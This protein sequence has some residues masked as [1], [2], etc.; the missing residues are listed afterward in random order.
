MFFIII[1]HFSIFSKSIKGTDRLCKVAKLSMQCCG[2]ILQDS[3]TRWSEPR[4]TVVCIYKVK[5]M[6][7]WLNTKCFRQVDNFFKSWFKMLRFLNS[8][9]SP[10]I[11]P[12]PP[13][14]PFPPPGPKSRETFQQLIIPWSFKLKA[15]VENFT[16]LSFYTLTTVILQ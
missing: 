2:Q 12:V 10:P 1:I 16:D 9:N 7:N 6:A 15:S 3:F 8:K 11:P 14:L 4:C 13:P 5:Q